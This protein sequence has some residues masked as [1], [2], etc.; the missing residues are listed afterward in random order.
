L[1]CE[2]ARH[3]VAVFFA[4]EIANESFMLSRAE[5]LASVRTIVIKLG[6]QTLSDSEG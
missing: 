2:N 4:A 5:Y 6:T 3:S 1:D